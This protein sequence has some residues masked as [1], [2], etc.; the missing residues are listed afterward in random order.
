MV[1]S[2]CTAVAQYSG[3]DC[4]KLKWSDSTGVG[5][6]TIEDSCLDY[7]RSIKVD[8]VT[9]LDNWIFT[10]A[11][12]IKITAKV[13]QDYWV[14]DTVRKAY[15]DSIYWVLGDTIIVSHP[16]SIVMR[17]VMIPD[18]VHFDDICHPCGAWRTIPLGC[19]DSIEI[20]IPWSVTRTI[21]DTICTLDGK[22]PRDTSYYRITDT[23]FQQLKALAGGVC[24]TSLSGTACLKQ[25]S[26]GDWII[27]AKEFD[28]YYPRYNC[29]LGTMCADPTICCLPVSTIYTAIWTWNWTKT[30]YSWVDPRKDTVNCLTPGAR[31]DTSNCR[32]TTITGITIKLIPVFVPDG[33]DTTVWVPDTCNGCIKAYSTCQ[34]VWVMDTTYEPI[35]TKIP[36][37]VYDTTYDTLSCKKT[38][39]YPTGVIYEGHDKSRSVKCEVLDGVVFSQTWSRTWTPGTYKVSRLNGPAG[40]YYTI[41]CDSLECQPWDAECWYI[42]G[43]A[44]GVYAPTCRTTETCKWSWAYYEAQCCDKDTVVTITCVGEDYSMRHDTTITYKVPDRS[45]ACPDT[46]YT[47]IRP[48]IDHYD[49]V[50]VGDIPRITSRFVGNKQVIVIEDTCKCVPQI[51][52]D[53]GCRPYCTVYIRKEC[54]DQPYWKGDTL[55]FP[56]E[57]SGN[58]ALSYASDLARATMKVTDSLRNRVMA[59]EDS[60]SVLRTALSGIPSDT[61]YYDDLVAYATLAKLPP[62]NP[63]TFNSDSITVDFSS[64]ATNIALYQFQMSHSTLQD[65][66]L[67]LHVHVH[68][69]RVDTGSV[70]WLCTYSLTNIGGGQGRW[71]MTAS[72]SEVFSYD[73]KPVYQIT[74]LFSIPSETVGPSTIL[75]LKLQRTGGDGGDTYEHS[76]QVL[77]VDVHYPTDGRGSKT[78]TSRY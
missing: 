54:G 71:N 68:W 45:A 28:P 6:I 9:A 16:D 56:C 63:A 50:K 73:G 69:T 19:Y 14:P 17:R 53:F 70:V 5:I 65:T 40:C 47:N 25:Q 48:Y 35:W 43:Y 32:D 24:W 23:E 8:S 31:R 74:S 46:I 13:S 34:G 55:V 30:E 41:N 10:Y 78:E 52:T 36:V 15:L 49:S 26:N 76:V 75:R 22:T 12:C 7:R 61:V 58:E 18:T 60:I 72:G 2:Y 67:D 27:N 11:G 64:S 3:S 21:C 42:P 38:Y 66:A 44:L 57:T 1:L 33:R 62:S 37:W 51:C 20:E 77:S 59:L 4:I 29:A 39:Y